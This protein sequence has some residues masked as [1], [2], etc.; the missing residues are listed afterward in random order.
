MPTNY[1]SLLVSGATGWHNGSG[2]IT[3]SFLGSAVPAYYQQVDT[4]SDGMA[5]AY[6]IS[7]GLYLPLDAIVQMSAAEQ[8]LS[9][10]AI[11][12]W[13]AVANINLVP[14]TVSSGGG[15]SDS[16]GTAVTGN[17]TLV[18]GLGGTTDF[19]ETEL[20]R[21]DD[22]S[23]AVDV[24]AVFEDGLNFFGNSYSS[25][26]V[27]TNGNITFGRSLSTYTPNGIT[28]ST[29]PIIAAFWADVDTRISGGLPDSQPIYVDVDTERD[30][31]TMTWSQVGYFSGGADKLNSFQIQLFDRGEGDF[32]IVFRYQ[33]INWTTGNASGGTGG[34]GGTV[35]RAGFSAGNGTDFYELAQSGDQ[36]A[37]LELEN[38]AGNTGVQGLYLFKVRNGEISV[39]D[40][41]FGAADF[42]YPGL[43][44]FV[45]DFAGT[46]GTPSPN[47]DLWIN[48]GN[49]TQ[50]AAA[51]GNSGWQTYLHELGHALGLHHPN[52]D[53]NNSAGD[54][55][56]NNQYTVMSY[57]QH[58]GETLPNP[59]S[60]LDASWPITPMIYDIQAAQALYGANFTT[61]TGNTTYFSS[62]GLYSLAD[63]GLLTNG[64]TA[65]AT[66][67]DAGGV[68]TF[69]LSE[70]TGAMVIDLRPGGFSTVGRIANNIAVMTPVS[71]AGQVVNLIEN[72]I[73]GSAADTI[74]GNDAAN[75]LDGRGGADTMA[76]G[77]GSDI[78]IVDNVGDVVVELNDAGTDV[79]YSS[80]SYSIATTFVET[81]ALTGSAHINA[82]GN[83]LAN[84]LFG[85]V[86]NNVLDGGAGADTMRGGIGND[87]YVVDNAGDVVIE[88]VNQG[89]D[90]VRTSLAIYGLAANVENL[91][92]TLATGQRLSGNGLNNVIVAGNGNDIINGGAG[93]DT[94]AGGLGNDSYYIDNAGDVIQ[95]AANGGNDTAYI[96]VDYTLTANSQVE[97]IAMLGTGNIN[98]T[99]NDLANTLIGNAGN[100]ILLGGLG[101]DM[102]LGGAGNDRLEGGEGFDT[103]SYVNATSGV[104]VGL[105]LTTAQDT[106]GAGIDTL[107]G[108]EGLLGSNFAD[109]LVGDAGNNTLIGGGGADT[110]RGGIGNDNYVVEDADDVVI[111]NG[112]QGVDTV[113]TALATYWLT[114]N[115]ENLIGSSAAG[116]ALGGNALNNTITGGAGNDRIVGGAGA[117]T[118]I[119]GLG[120]DIYSVDRSDDVVIEQANQGTD[121]VYSSVSYSIATQFVEN[122]GLTGTANIDATGN[123]L[124]NILIGN[125]GNNVIDGRGGRD[126]ITGGAGRDQFNFTTALGA[127]NIDTILDF[128]VA[129]DTIALSRAIFTAAGPAGV[130]AS[131]AFHTG[132]AAAD[133]L[134]RIIY[135]SATGALLY[136]A[137]GNGAGGAMQFAQLAAGLS[138]TNADF[139]LI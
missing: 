60:N 14:G 16:H 122:I 31:V 90:T 75:Q 33:D 128:S 126:T 120:N 135:N 18:G 26:Y 34:L 78:Y 56:N 99:G 85:N 80:V 17:G 48:Q 32:D 133:A 106:R 47:G 39:G 79:V 136:D 123:S 139:L 20:P 49:S 7:E 4:N 86:G 114:D 89:T 96:S 129:D 104:V 28:G 3:Y 29:T 61:N 42:G 65:I 55:T 110:L 102:L 63:G 112:N 22:G 54:A 91:L 38:T 25:I 67:W 72:A 103:A 23:A 98:L 64:L 9:V 66:I 138:M 97:T 13:N 30:V 111:E 124:Y 41:T 53:P 115:V 108:I 94:M 35:A 74:Y 8:A 71:N 6:E 45:S 116:Q 73:G 36:A 40:I 2:Q 68:D 81:M 58:P 46:P 62:T 88:N 76:G 77:L 50:N 83:A 101:N 51:F 109:V 95:E 117:D 93:A 44:G 118:M 69:D 113:R 52:E 1:Q 137:D 21:N 92:G 87:T 131:T 82:T 121:A 125:S 127:G 19:G 27:N 12:A 11:N 84:T 119:G 105:Y 100:N 10:Q 57:V 43:F 70:Q 24:S 107:V 15:G 134:D 37:I 5:D 130:L 132:A 59:V